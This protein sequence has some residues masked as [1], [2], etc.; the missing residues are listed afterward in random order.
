MS[1]F[2]NDSKSIESNSIRLQFESF[3]SHLINVCVE[4]IQNVINQVGSS[5]TGPIPLPTRRRIYCVLRSPHV[6]KDAREHFEIR[7]YKKIMDVYTQSSDIIDSFF[8][9]DL[10]PGVSITLK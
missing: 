2:T 6:N 7:K 1:S 3:D 10:P 4:K 8:K 9:I 5:S